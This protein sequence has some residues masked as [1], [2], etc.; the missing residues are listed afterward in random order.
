MKSAGSSAIC[1][2]TVPFVAFT[3]ETDGSILCPCTPEGDAVARLRL[4]VLRMSENWQQ[5]ALFL[6]EQG[7]LTTNNVTERAIGRWRM[8][9]R[10]M[11][12]FTSLSGLFTAFQDL[13]EPGRAIF[14]IFANCSGDNIL[15]PNRKPFYFFWF[16]NNFCEPFE[17][18]HTFYSHIKKRFD[19]GT[20]SRGLCYAPVTW[21]GGIWNCAD[22]VW[23]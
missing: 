20:T 3:L 23:G 18:I 21:H 22:L 19:C 7:V 13:G 16:Y 10:T 4:W 9:S 6:Q 15:L 5:Y 1:P 8:C 17:A 2:T 11:R 14:Y 12:G